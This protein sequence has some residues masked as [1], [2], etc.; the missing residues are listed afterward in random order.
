MKTEIVNIKTSLKQDELWTKLRSITVTD[1]SKINEL[2]LAIYYGSLTPNSFDLKSVRY[3]PMSAAPSIEG[4]IL[5]SDNDV[6]VKLK[7]DIQS[8]YRLIRKMCFAT[9]LPIGIVILLL[10]LLFLGGTKFQLHGI[11]FS[12]F[13]ILGALVYVSIIRFVLINTKKREQKE[14]IA[15]IDGHVINSKRVN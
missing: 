10:S 6:N 1:F 12:S 9:L 2:P 8:N 5:N 15:T 14:F 7:M 13:F 11:I 3:T 4:E